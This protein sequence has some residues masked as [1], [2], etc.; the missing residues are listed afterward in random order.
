MT[1]TR[2]RPQHPVLCMPILGIGINSAV[3]NYHHHLLATAGSVT[4][5]TR[6]ARTGPVIKGTYI[7]M[8]GW[9]VWLDHEATVFLSFFPSLS[10]FHGHLR[11]SL[12]CLVSP[13][14]SYI[15]SES[16][17][18]SSSTDTYLAKL[19]RSQIWIRTIGLYS[20]SGV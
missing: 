13:S 8:C 12:A 3:I 5:I 15:Y 10:N 7:C 2:I 17:V 6:Y 18:G 16:C 20:V 19:Q 11:F 9:I 1:N 4:Y 14:I